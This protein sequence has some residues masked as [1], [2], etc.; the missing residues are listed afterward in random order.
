VLPG[1]K[2]VRLDVDI[3]KNLNV[4]LRGL[5]VVNVD[6]QGS[7][8]LAKNQV[9]RDRSKNIDIQDHFTRDF[10]KEQRI[11]LEYIPA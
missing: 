3:L 7:I 2:G 6:N 8:A 10:V 4:S 9:F 11:H 5:M 1:I